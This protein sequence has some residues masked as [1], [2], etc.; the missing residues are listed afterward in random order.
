MQH[1]YY[2]S[3]FQ[4]IDNIMQLPF[5]S[6]VYV[7][8]DSEYRKIRKKQAEDEIA[9]LQKRLEAYERSALSLQETIDELRSEHEIALPE[10]SEE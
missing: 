3:P 8:S 9:V 6:D 1:S 10:A 5:G 4:L 2:R 7:I